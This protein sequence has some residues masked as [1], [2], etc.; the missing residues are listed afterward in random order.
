MKMNLN[1]Q[2]FRKTIDFTDLFHTNNAEQISQF[3]F[4]KIILDYEK[5]ILKKINNEIN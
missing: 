1:L 2:N 3:F 4:E 5:E